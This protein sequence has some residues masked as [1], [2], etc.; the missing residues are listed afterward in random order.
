MLQLVQSPN[1]SG[2]YSTRVFLTGTNSAPDFASCAVFERLGPLLEPGSLA[3]TNYPANGAACAVSECLG[4]V[5]DPGSLAGEN[6]PADAAA[7]AVSERFGSLVDPSSPGRYEV[8]RRCC[9]LCS[10]SNALGLSSTQ[11]LLACMN[12]FADA[13]ACVVPEQLG[14]LLDPGSPAGTNC[15]AKS[16]ACV[17]SKRLGPL[18]ERGFLADTKFLADAAAC[19]VL[20]RLGSYSSRVSGHKLSDR[21]CSLCNLQTPRAF[22]RPGFPGR[23]ELCHRCC[24]L[25][26]LRT[27]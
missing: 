20:K 26:S 14:S 5:L 2:F 1:V 3:G 18:L 19:A 25:F 22:T 6:C 21:C 7:C 9:S 27:P 8:S 4:P 15:P 11:V 23:H 24:N 16:S 17:V 10:F 13:A 12:C